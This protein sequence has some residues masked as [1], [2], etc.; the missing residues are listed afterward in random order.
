MTLIT[1]EIDK[2]KSDL[3]EMAFLVRKQLRQC[4]EAII[5][6]DTTLIEKVRDK[7]KRINR[8]DLQVDQRCEEIIALYQ[9]VA[10]DLRFLFAAI[11]INL[12]LEMIGDN[13][14]SITQYI[15]NL[16]EPVEKQLFEIFHL[17]LLILRVNSL[18]DDAITA[19]FDNDAHFARSLFIKDDTIDRIYRYSQMKSEQVIKEN[20]D[21]LHNILQLLAIIKHLEKIADNTLHIVEDTLFYLEGVYYKH[22]AFKDRSS[23]KPE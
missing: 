23:P 11:K 10:I 2:L 5:S 7:E 18:F 22:P 20:M 15:E 4:T 14:N 12:Y 19:F 9:P 3:K 17:D 21:Q 6:R 16:K 13:A 1:Q 8:Y